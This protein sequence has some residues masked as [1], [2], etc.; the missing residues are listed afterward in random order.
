[1]QQYAGSKK[2]QVKLT[3]SLI[4]CLV[5]AGLIAVTV[6]S[7]FLKV[8]LLAITLPFAHLAYMGMIQK[9]TL[10][11]ATLAV[12]RPLWVSKIKIED[13]AFCAVH[14]LEEG[15]SLVYCFVRRRFR[16]GVVGIKSKESFD[17]LVEMLMKD[18]GNFQTDLD[19]NF[20]R[21]K[22]IPVSFVASGE[23][24]KDALLLAVDK[25]HLKR[26]GHL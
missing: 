13:I 2:T 1:M 26:I 25:A 5:I 10:D 20:H 4:M 6:D 3:W 14:G 7:L 24:L 17:T 12:H 23:Q 19:I 16:P 18:Q 9:I 11:D 8:F 21:A 15:K 22:K